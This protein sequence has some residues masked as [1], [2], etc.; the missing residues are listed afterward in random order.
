MAWPM[1]KGITISSKKGERAKMRFF[2]RGEGENW[3]WLHITEHMDHGGGAQG[4]RM[5][6]GEV[7][8]SLK[9]GE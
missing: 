6:R 1:G 8:L 9:Q 7:I 5:T 2:E 4:E 3:P